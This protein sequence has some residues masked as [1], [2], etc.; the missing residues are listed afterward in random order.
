MPRPAARTGLSFAGV[1]M[2]AVTIGACGSTAA[3]PVVATPV[4]PE[5]PTM[6]VAPTPWPSV[7]ELPTEMADHP[8]FEQILPLLAYRGDRPFGVV[9]N[10]TQVNASGATV[11]DITYVGAAGEAVDAYLML[12]G[13][14]PGASGPAAGGLP[15]IL[16]VHGSGGSRVEFMYEATR[17]A[18][19][20]HMVGLVISRP[21]ATFD[22]DP[23]TSALLDVREIR[24]ALDLL[25]AQ[26][27]VDPARLGYVGF[28]MGAILGTVALPADRRVK[29]ATLMS[30]VPSY[31]LPDLNLR[32]FAP[33]VTTP[34][35]LLQFGSDDS[36]YTRAEAESFAALMPATHKVVWYE[37][38]HALNAAAM[39]E[40]DAWLAERLSAE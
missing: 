16:Y 22:A 17:V 10:G 33:H 14:E 4:P 26:P 2:L 3:T 36:Y 40:R 23:L 25:A 34:T 15:G 30:V 5:V 31:G 24:R 19:Q 35:V 8:T 37:A 39:M 27:E 29:A 12:P 32:L 7:V 1:L 6:T 20:Q 38:G 18:E 28:S 11:A 21:I 13:K 9:V